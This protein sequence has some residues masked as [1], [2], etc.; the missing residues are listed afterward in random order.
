MDTFACTDFPVLEL[1]A[2][3]SSR[4]I[5]KGLRAVYKQT[6]DRYQMHKNHL[7]VNVTTLFP[8]H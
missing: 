3:H 7:D 8:G 5:L 6:S 2:L 4:W 1:H